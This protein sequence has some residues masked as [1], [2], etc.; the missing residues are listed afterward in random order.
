MLADGL[1]QYL[2][3][4]QWQKWLLVVGSHDGRQALGRRAATRP[5]PRFGAKIV[6]ERVFEDTGGARR[7]DS[8]VAD[9]ASNPAV[10]ARAAG[11]RRARRRG[12]ERSFRRL[13]ALPDLGPA[14]G[15]GFG[16]PDADELG[17]LERPMGRTQMQNRFVKL[18][19]RRMTALDMQ[20]WTAA[21]MVGEA[22]PRRNSGDPKTGSASSREKI[23]RAC[24]LQGP[25]AHL[26]GLELAASAADPARRWTHVVSVSPQ[27]GFL[28]PV[29][30]T[31]YARH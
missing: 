27:E 14:A 2:V 22:T 20:A 11:L 18:N 25:A 17:R 9:P 28:H 1:G 19:S 31:R 4:K 15:G 13:S 12:R 24:R 26:A 6:Q 23:F 5:R 8:G 29:L 21:R 10:Y 16:G 7:T 3:W 30:R